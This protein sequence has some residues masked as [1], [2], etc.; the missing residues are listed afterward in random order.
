MNVLLVGGEGTF[1]ASVIREF[2]KNGH[3]V[4]LLT[5]CKKN[6]KTTYPSVFERYDF[7]CSSESVQEIVKSVS[8]EVVLFFGAYDTNYSWYDAKRDAVHYAAD[9]TNILTAYASRSD[10]LFVYLS[11]EAVFSGKPQDGR[12]AEQ[13][14]AC[15]ADLRAAAIRQGEQSCSSFRQCGQFRTVVVRVE[16]VYGNPCPAQPD[17]CSEMILEALQ[18]GTITLP[19]ETAV[20]MLYVT[21]AAA[22][23]Y[24][25]ITAEKREHALYHLAAQATITPEQIAEQIAEQLPGTR[26]VRQPEQDK[27]PVLLSA[28]RFFQEF[29]GGV[30]VLY[31]EGIRENIRL[32]QNSR[33]QRTE[34]TGQAE[35]PLR[36]MLGR[37]GKTL[38]PYLETV[39]CFVPAFMLHNRAASGGLFGRV[40]FFLLY[41]LLMAL[42]HGQSAAGCA[43]VLASAGYCFRQMHDRTGMD[44]L[45]D[46]N[47]YLWIAQLFMVGMTTGYLKDRIISQRKD[48][49]GEIRSLKQRLAEMTQINRS[50]VRINQNFEKQLLHQRDSMGRLYRITAAL[51]QCSAE[52]VLFSAA[53]VLSELM[54][55]PSA[56]VY[57][58]E[59]NGSARLFSF[60]SQQARQLGDTL[61]C[62]N[63]E[64]MA[65]ELSAKRV[66]VNRTLSPKAPLMAC[67]VYE[68][69]KLSLILMLW[70]LPWERMTLSEVDRLQTAGYLIQDAVHSSRQY[71]EALREKRYVKGLP[72]LNEAAFRQMARAFLEAKAQGLTECSFI[73]LENVGMTEPEKCRKLQS[74]LCR[75]DHIGL[76]HGR[77]HVLLSI[78]DAN[79]V[80]CQLA[81]AGI[82]AHIVPEEEIT[83]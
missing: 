44:V 68:K 41:V 5:G 3:R 24:R 47:T 55:T 17:L 18:S 21:D 28:D 48:A 58:V 69:E 76:A 2:E 82:R 66:Y 49:E 53:R 33:K 81:Q 80:L 29:G 79:K 31:A 75:T 9:L 4:F 46:Y 54:D 22:L 30:R 59:E 25:I 72:L 45:L 34:K 43:A 56:A 51:Q 15:P 39:L 8:P 12:I 37:V 19:S 83:A 64:E 65:K 35:K 78:A 23:L 7:P 67:G 42:V 60:T 14:E 1:M 6:D 52:E 63:M 62:R 13:T 40:D 73:T 57:V 32:L 50:N 20:S 74:M 16:R 11:S 71:S 27:M 61:C 36:R 38:L 77:I 26:L 70:A 10:G